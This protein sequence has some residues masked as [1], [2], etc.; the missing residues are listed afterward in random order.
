MEALA[1]AIADKLAPSIADRLAATVAEKLGA[2]QT[3]VVSDGG[4][5]DD[6]F[7]WAPNRKIQGPD[8]S[9]YCREVHGV[10]VA[11]KTF[12][13]LRSTGNGPKLIYLGS[14]PYSTP[15][16][17]DEWLRERMV[18]AGS[19]TEHQAL[20]RAAAKAGKHS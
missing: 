19:T 8:Q 6:P 5:S 3:A 1:A 11:P 15:A 20:S 16:F 7:T 10:K 18:K 12:E 17:L 13:K 4:G 9:R 2:M 14:R